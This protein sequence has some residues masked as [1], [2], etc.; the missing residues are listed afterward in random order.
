VQRVVV[1]IVIVNCVDRLLRFLLVPPISV[2]ANAA[3]MPAHLVSRS[4]HH[5]PGQ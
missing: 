2:D 1:I 3:I 4:G 5:L